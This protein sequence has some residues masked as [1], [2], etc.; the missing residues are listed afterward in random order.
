LFASASKEKTGLLISL[1]GGAAI[2]KVGTK[3]PNDNGIQTQL[4]KLTCNFDDAS[5]VAAM[6]ETS[7][8]AKVVVV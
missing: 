7:E 2:A 5:F 8:S 4:Q 6:T 3:W 1:G